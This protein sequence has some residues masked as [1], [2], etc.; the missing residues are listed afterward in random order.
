MNTRERQSWRDSAAADWVQSSPKPHR[1]RRTLSHRSRQNL[2][3]GKTR[4]SKCRPCR[5]EESFAGASLTAAR[6]WCTETI[7]LA[8]GPIHVVLH[9]EHLTM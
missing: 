3:I 2:R 4:R 6:Q 9:T 7:G 5:R 1:R 8:Q